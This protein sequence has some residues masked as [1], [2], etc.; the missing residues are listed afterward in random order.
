VEVKEEYHIKISNR[1]R[2]FKYFYV[3]VDD[4]DDNVEIN[5]A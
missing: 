2:A 3:V 4:D 1:F 5:S